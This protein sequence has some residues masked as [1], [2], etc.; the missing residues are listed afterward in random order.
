MPDRILTEITVATINQALRLVG[1]EQVEFV[2]THVPGLGIRVRPRGAKWILRGRLGK[3]QTTWTIADASAL[4]PKKARERAHE[5]RRLIR[6]GIDPRDWLAEQELGGKV[7]RKFDPAVDG[8]TFE[9]ARTIYLGQVK[10]SNRPETY[11]DYR[12]TLSS[13]HCTPLVGKLLK[14]ITQNDVRHVREKTAKVASRTMAAKVTS[15]VK[16]LLNWAAEQPDSGIDVSIGRDVKTGT[17]KSDRKKKPPPKRQIAA[18]I[19]GL[20]ELQCHQSIRLACMLTLLTAQRR[21]TVASARKDEFEPDPEGKMGAIWRIS[22]SLMKRSEAHTIPIPPWTWS[23]VKA[24]MKLSTASSPWVFP[25]LRKRNAVDPGNGHL[26]DSEITHTFRETGCGFGPHSVRMMLAT[27]GEQELGFLRSDTKA[28][29]HHL[30]GESADVTREHYVRH[31]GKHFKWRI[32]QQWT[33]FIYLQMLENHPKGLE[34][35]TYLPSLT[36]S[37]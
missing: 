9:D 30:E 11:N 4:S 22:S 21:H 34:Y 31:D 32:I 37:K 24:A 26:S 15:A 16:R 36:G 29:L 5:A 23:I 18:L 2:D 33:S 1:K 19:F 27:Y 12:K 20:G 3:S 35:P 7:E 25:Q 13:Q 28:I 6:R 17:T 14:N 8:L 10:E